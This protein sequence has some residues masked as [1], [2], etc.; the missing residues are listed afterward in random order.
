MSKTYAYIGNWTVKSQGADGGIAVY[1]YDEKEGRLSYI[2][3]VR[4]DLVAGL[5]CADRKRGV[6]YSIDETQNHASFANFGGGGRVA[7]FKIDPASGKLSE[8]GSEQPSFSTLPTYVAQ[9]NSGEFLVVANHGDKQAITK[10]YRGDDG[11]YHITTDFS[12]VNAALYP[13]A[14]DGSIL[15]ACDLMEFPPDISSNPPRIA[16]L[17]SFYFDPKSDLAMMSNMKQNELLMLRIDRERRR[18]VKVGVL[19]CKEGNWPRYGA[20]H[21]H[22]NI[23]YLNNEHALEI[24]VVSY[25]ANG[26]MEQLQTVSCQPDFFLDRTGKRPLQQTDIHISADGKY[27]YGACRGG[28][29]IN[30]YAIGEDGLLSRLQSFKLEGEAPRG[31]EIAPDGRFLLVADPEAGTVATVAIGEDGRLSATGISDHSMAHPA[32]IVFYRAE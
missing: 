23:F 16:C 8:L 3:S 2:E 32:P 28:G 9:D 21:P 4:G 30:V 20:F 24:N 29:V 17:H 25:N 11:A 15:P 19:H 10:T 27:L 31:F 14:E 12:V 7:A 18:L 13:V 1:E 26:A 22:K 5:I 6:I